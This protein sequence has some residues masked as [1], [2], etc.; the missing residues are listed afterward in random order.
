MAKL[1]VVI[2][3]LSCMA[4]AASAANPFSCF[5]HMKK[6]NNN[7][8]KNNPVAAPVEAPRVQPVQPPKEIDFDGLNKYLVESLPGNV[9]RE[10][11]VA[12]LKEN[13]D[14]LE[15]GVRKAAQLALDLVNN[16]GAQ[17]N[18]QVL[19]TIL[20]LDQ[21]GLAPNNNGRTRIVNVIKKD[22]RA[23]EAACEHLIQSSYREA[24]EELANFM[25]NFKPT[26]LANDA[27][28]YLTKLD[29]LWYFRKDPAD[30]FRSYNTYD[31]ELTRGDVRGVRNDAAKLQK[32]MDEY[33]FEPCERL[34]DDDQLIDNLRALRLAN[35]AEIDDEY[36]GKYFGDQYDLLQEL[37][38]LNWRREACGHLLALDEEA[39]ARIA[40]DI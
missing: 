19:W 31:D 4:L 7:N 13:L 11:N 15:G 23:V 16:S 32:T 40:E 1:T 2:V 17:C 8:N 21:Q 27:S 36:L 34:V 10:A 3:L 30:D 22:W 6:N 26:N 12:Q 28:R 35:T 33:L 5:G 18:K 38:N 9:E 37:K 25:Y 24:D 20:K 29:T 14:S 39:R